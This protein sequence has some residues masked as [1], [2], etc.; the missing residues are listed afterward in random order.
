MR[1]HR[2]RHQALYRTALESRDVAVET[3]TRPE[4]LEISQ[5][6]PGFLDFREA[7]VGVLAGSIIPAVAFT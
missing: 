2:S 6:L 5:P 3:P 4:A 1:E 7:R